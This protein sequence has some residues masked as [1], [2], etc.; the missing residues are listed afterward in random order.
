VEHGSL[1]QQL[2]IPVG[3]VHFVTDPERQIEHTV[4]LAL[5]MGHIAVPGKPERINQP[6]ER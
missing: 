5:Q 1:F 4:S 2:H 6:D 3:K